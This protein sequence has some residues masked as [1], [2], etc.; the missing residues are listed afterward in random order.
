MPGLIY[1]GRV[2]DIRKSGLIGITTG[3]YPGFFFLNSGMLDTDLKNGD[4]DNEWNKWPVHATTHPPPLVRHIYMNTY[5]LRVLRKIIT[6]N[7]HKSVLFYSNM[8]QIC[9]HRW[10]IW[11]FSGIMMRPTRNFIITNMVH[12][13]HMEHDKYDPGKPHKEQEFHFTTFMP[14]PPSYRIEYRL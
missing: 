8:S 12:N 4:K 14:P 1:T 3:A 10:S 7:S 13:V 2:Q 5:K 11:H 9:I 6:Y